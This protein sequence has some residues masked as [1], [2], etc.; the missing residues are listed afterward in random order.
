M[1]SIQ[2]RGKGYRII[3]SNG[4]DINGVKITDTATWIPEPGMK[5]KEIEAALNLFAAEFERDVKAGKNIKGSRMTL[6]ELSVPYLEDM[7]PPVLAR[8]SY[9]DYKKRLELRILPAMGHIKIGNIRQKTLNDYKKMLRETYI[10]PSTKKPLS[11]ASVS[12]D[13]LIVSA[14]ISYAVSQGLLDLNMLIYSGKV[15]GRKKPRKEAKPQH[16]TVEQLIRFIDALETPMEVLHQEHTTTV[17]GETYTVKPYTQT[18]RVK[19]KWKL[20]FYISMFAG[21]RRGE[22]IS[23]TWNDLNMTTREVTIKTSTDYVDGTMELKDTKTHN[24]RENTLPA[25]VIEVAKAWKSEQMQGALKLGGKWKGY[26]GKEYDKNFI[27][28]QHNGSQMHICS[29]AGEFKRIIRLYNQ[30]IADTPEKKIPED[31]SPHGLRHSVAAILIA[32]NVDVRTVAGILGHADPTTTLNIY[33][34]FFK[35]KG[36]EAAGIMEDKLLSGKLVVTK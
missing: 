7:K 36:K 33:S 5:K 25:Y 28:T 22:N 17:K 35:N 13:C 4:Y 31:V 14:M 34:Y 3:V 32:N 2:K 9:A 27:F 1:A 6:Q 21:D 18:F 29:P 15:T 10:S 19:P 30:C 20:Y 23:L 12:K 24:E 16:F 8:T 26:H 11:E